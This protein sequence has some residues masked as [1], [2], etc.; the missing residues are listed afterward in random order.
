LQLSMMWVN[1]SIVAWKYLSIPHFLSTALLWSGF[2][3]IKSGFNLHF[4]FSSWPKI[5]RIPRSEKRTPLS[6]GTM[7][8]LKA[9]GARLG[10]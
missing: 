9:V 2:Y 10:F 8:Y 6:K 5:F 3:L 7:N 4:F 1:K